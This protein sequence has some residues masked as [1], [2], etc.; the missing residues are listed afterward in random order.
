MIGKRN[1]ALESASCGTDKLDF[2]SFKILNHFIIIHWF[3]FTII[4]ATSSRQGFKS[5]YQ[6][7]KMRFMQHGFEYRVEN[8]V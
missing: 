2:L 8:S 1:Q 6:H 5:I 3:G 4:S 7:S